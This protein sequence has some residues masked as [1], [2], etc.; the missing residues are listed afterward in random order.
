MT[1]LEIIVLIIFACLLPYQVY[2]D[3]KWD[4]RIHKYDDDERDKK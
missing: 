1:K 4:K 3:I 2:K